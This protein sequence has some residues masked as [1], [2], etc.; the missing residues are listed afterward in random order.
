[1]SFQLWRN[2]YLPRPVQDTEGEARRKALVHTESTAPSWAIGHACYLPSA[3]VYEC[4]SSIPGADLGKQMKLDGYTILSH[5]KGCSFTIYLRNDIVY[6]VFKGTDSV[7]TVWQDTRMA[8]KSLWH[9][10][11]SPVLGDAAPP[12]FVDTL[13]SSAE[14][15]IGSTYK[16][17][18]RRY[19]GH[20]LGGAYAMRAYLTYGRDEDMCHV[21]APYMGSPLALSVAKSKPNFPI[22]VWAHKDDPVWNTAKYNYDSVNTKE[23]T[24]FEPLVWH[25]T[26]RGTSQA[27]S[28]TGI[29]RAHTLGHLVRFWEDGPPTTA[30]ITLTHIAPQ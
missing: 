16:G 11:S 26:S 17:L 4:D 7:A 30:N 29:E 19:V 10:I 22:V 2:R 27:F 15:A 3:K 21:F 6:V 23:S 24:E 13:L 1:M 28:K 12:S 20:S 18:P 9:K 14:S 25:D 8:A 5:G